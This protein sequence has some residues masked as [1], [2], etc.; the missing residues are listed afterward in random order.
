MGP[1]RGSRAEREECEGGVVRRRQLPLEEAGRRCSD[2]GVAGAS[3]GKV[4]E[5]QIKQTTPDK[6]SVSGGAQG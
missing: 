3:T 2:L 4:S 5:E 1:P 6:V